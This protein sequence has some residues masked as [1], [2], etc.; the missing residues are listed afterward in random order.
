MKTIRTL[1]LAFLGLFLQISLFSQTQIEGK[2]LAVSGEGI[3]FANVLLLDATD[4]TLVKGALTKEDGSYLLNADAGK[5]FLIEVNMVGYSSSYTD[6]FTVSTNSPQTLA[7]L[8]LTEGVE[9]AEVQV[10]ARK[11]LFEQKIDRMVVNVANSVTSAGGTALEVLERSPGVL[12]NR[13]SQALSLV[14]KSGVVIMINGKVTYQ[15]ASGIVQMLQGMSADNIE[16]IELITTPPAK[17]DAEGDAGFINIVLKKR[18]DL[19]LNGNFSTS[20]GYGDGE[21]AS[22]NLNLNYRNQK[23]NIFSTY[24]FLWESQLQ[25]FY[26]YRKVLFDGQSTESEVLTNRDPTQRNNNLRLGLDYEWSDKTVIGVLAAAYDNKWTMDAIND[27]STTID[28]VLSSEIKLVNE[29][30]NQWKHFMSNVNLQHEFTPGTKLNVDV[31]YLIYEDENPNT[32]ATSYFGDN[33]NLLRVEDTR[34][35]KF[36]PIDI[37]VGQIAFEKKIGERMKY[38]GGLKGTMSQFNNDVSVEVLGVKDWEVLPQFTNKSDLEEK[39]FAAYSSLDFKASEKNA[40]K[41]GLRYEYTDSQLNSEKEGQVVD[42]QFGSLFPSLFYTRTINENQS[43]NFS[44]TRRITRPT[45]NDMAP[46]AIFL[47]PNTYFFGNA[48]LQP[49]ISNNVKVDYRLKSYVL[50]IQYTY[51]DSTI[52]RFQDRVVV[53]TNQ[54]S[55]E[56]ANLKNT[57]SVSLSL[58]LPFY[59]G[60]FW[61]MQNNIFVLWQ[62][63]NSFYDDAPVQL[64]NTSF[65]INTNQTFKLARDYSL[66]LSAFYSSPG[67]FGRSTFDAIKGVNFGFQKKFANNGGSLRFNVGDIFNSV[68]FRGGTNLPDQGFETDGYFDFSRRTFRLSYSRNFG[69]NKLKASRRRSTG[70]EAERNRVN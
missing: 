3:S 50:S 42:R 66:E 65:N 14:G 4:S 62:E 61:E 10:V 52:A 2:V 29:E 27:G 8:T 13:Q 43:A 32:Y 23:I 37:W 21:T 41:F 67:I 5:R 30:R 47:D 70:S 45:F 17:F 31:D 9:L 24:S 44:F 18:T 6:V 56:P 53:E 15:P 35:D 22:A 40:F 57:Q 36:T 20:V 55:F 51:E 25:E 11:P 48:A 60:D 39:I 28:N 38:E 26:N 16:R 33:S 19:G 59:I 49:A 46:F 34:S 7:P 54:Q 12:V 58:G 1:G 63:V 64:S 69:N 68:V